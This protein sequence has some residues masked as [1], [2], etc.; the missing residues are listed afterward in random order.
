MLGFMQEHG[1]YVIDNGKTAFR[2]NEFSWNKEANVLYI[3]QPAGVGYSYCDLKNAPQDCKFNDDSS[4]V[5]NLEVTL[6]WFAKFPE[7]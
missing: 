5:D 1:P 2:K 7:Y 6:A 4:A 3:E